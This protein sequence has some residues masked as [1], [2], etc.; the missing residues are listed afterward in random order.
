LTIHP[1]D[2]EIC[3]PR[4]VAKGLTRLDRN[5]LVS[6]AR[7]GYESGNRL[8]DVVTR[9]KKMQMDIDM[10]RS[11]SDQGVDTCVEVRLRKLH[12][13]VLDE[14]I[15]ARARDFR[16]ELDEGFARGLV[17]RSVVD[18]QDRALLKNRIRH[19]PSSFDAPFNV[20]P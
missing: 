3:D 6:L 18:D 17:S 5:R 8:A 12:M 10:R 14:P 19:G 11:A 16:G 20:N 15:R 13:R 2:D 9:A 1:V 7:S 4:I